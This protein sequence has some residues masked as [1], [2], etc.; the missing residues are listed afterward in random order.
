[1]PAKKATKEQLEYDFSVLKL[2]P[3]QVAEKYGYNPRSI[4][5]AMKY[6]NLEHPH[7]AL[8]YKTLSDEQKQ[9][10][11][12]SLMGDGRLL[13][14]GFNWSFRV[15]HCTAQLAL[16]EWKS[17]ILGDWITPRGIDFELKMGKHGFHTITTYTHSEFSSLQPFFYPVPPKKVISLETLSLIEPM[18][19]SVWFMDDG[20][21]LTK[22]RGVRIHTSGFSFDENYLIRDWFLDRWG[23]VVRV[24]KISGGYPVIT[25]YGDESDKFISIIK[26]W[27]LPCMFYKILDR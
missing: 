22:K 5:R 21:H 10:I 16:V 23:I 19:L 7:I 3:Q 9:V 8:G 26:P 25:I 18:G 4:W 11:V 12:G 1:M 15:G 13:K 17:N 20:S 14:N 2:T 24:G 6:R 27:I